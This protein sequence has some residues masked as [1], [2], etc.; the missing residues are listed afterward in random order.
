MSISEEYGHRLCLCLV[1]LLTGKIAYSY[2]YGCRTNS[3]C[4]LKNVYCSHIN[5]QAPSNI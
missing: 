2:L 1:Y 3:H 5:L 4:D